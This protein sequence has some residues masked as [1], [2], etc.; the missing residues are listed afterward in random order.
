MLTM[1]VEQLS[2]TLRLFVNQHV[3]ELSGGGFCNICLHILAVGSVK[4]DTICFANAKTQQAV[5]RKLQLF[6]N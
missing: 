1:L 6:I 2:L 5:L 3:C 4:P